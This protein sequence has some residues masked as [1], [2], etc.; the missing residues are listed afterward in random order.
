MQLPKGSSMSDLTSHQRK[1]LLLAS[2]SCK[3]E[4]HCDVEKAVITIFKTVKEIQG[5]DEKK[6]TFEN[7]PFWFHYRAFY[8]TK[9]KHFYTEWSI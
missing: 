4:W 8:F 9:K 3:R 2:Y 1:W 5:S 6:K 7:S